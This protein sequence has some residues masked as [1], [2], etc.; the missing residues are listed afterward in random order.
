M[1]PRKRNHPIDLPGHLSDESAA[2][3]VEFLEEITRVFESR[4]FA[5]IRR[6]YDSLR[7]DTMSS[8]PAQA[9][10]APDPNDPQADPF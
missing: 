10:P 8:V 1:P 7:A 4:Y 5:Q 6:Y 3:I 9:H 2:D